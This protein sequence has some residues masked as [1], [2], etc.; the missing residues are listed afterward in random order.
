[1]TEAGVRLIIP[2]LDTY[3]TWEYEYPALTP[4]TD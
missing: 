4:L 1:M 3:V 2:T